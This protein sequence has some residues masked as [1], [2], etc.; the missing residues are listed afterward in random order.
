MVNYSLFYSCVQFCHTHCCRQSMSGQTCGLPPTMARGLSASSVAN[1]PSP[2]GRWVD[3]PRGT[4][5]PGSVSQVRV[6]WLKVGCQKARLKK[7]RTPWRLCHVAF[8]SC[9]LCCTLAKTS[10]NEHSPD[11][12]FAQPPM[13]TVQLVILPDY[14]CSLYPRHCF[15]IAFR[16][17]MCLTRGSASHSSASESETVL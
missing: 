6:Q 16:C 4:P 7:T 15:N 14:Q 5:L 12:Q 17:E 13:L 10:C 9:L 3:F 8:S 2:A 1:P 11:S